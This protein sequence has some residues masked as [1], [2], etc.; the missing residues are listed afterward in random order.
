M[1]PPPS[2]SAAAVPTGTPLPTPGPPLPVGPVPSGFVAK[3]VTFASVQ[4]GWVL[5]TA[6]CGTT[7]CLSLLRTTDGGRVWTSIPTPPAV[8]SI[9]YQ[10]GVK[11]V[12]FADL[13]DGWLFKP[14]LWATHDGG[15][16]W[17]RVRLPGIEADS[18]VFDVEAAAGLVHAAIFDA[19]GNRIETSPVG[20][21]AWQL[22]S[23]TIQSG[24][25]PVPM[26][27]IVLQGTTGWLVAIDRTITG[28]AR[29]QNGRWLGWQPPCAQAGGPVVLAASTPA[30]LT[31]V[32]D[33]GVWGPAPSGMGFHSY[34]S[35]DGG[36]H[37]NRTWTRLPPG[38]CG[39]VATSQPGEA[40]VSGV[41]NGVEGLFGTFDNGATWTAVYRG[42]T[43][44]D[45]GF[46]S[47][48]QGVSLNPDTGTL[49]MTFDGGHHWNPVE[50]R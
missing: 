15:T 32:C 37:F 11:M 28:G 46:T 24:A 3:S 29:L 20:A 10:E 27:Q 39:D 47:R 8:Y 4:V 12:R 30:D 17:N 44:A 16:H 42:S 25:G 45:L 43:G 26:A 5:G 13:H 33:E 22:S 21:E 18:E 19:T 23:T 36:A 2:G 35:T 50:F 41:V 34:L 38:C 48:S 31:A 40:I 14:D 49:L 6:P 9:G 7:N 1:V